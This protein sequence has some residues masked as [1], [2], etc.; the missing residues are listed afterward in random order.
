MKE[1]FYQQLGEAVRRQ[2]LPNGLEVCVVPKPE[3][4][5]KYAFFAV[6]YGGMDT[7]FSLQGR[8]MDTPAGIAHYL[9]HKMFDT[10]DGS[11]MQAL[12]Q[13]GAEPNAFTS[14]AMTAYY[15]DSTKHFE[16]NLKILLS[17]VSQPYFTKESVAKEQG[18]IRQEIRM[19]EDSPDYQIYI[20]LL[21]AM[22]GGHAAATSVV[23]S[24]ESIAQ[25][26]HQTLYDCHRAFY[27]P[28]NM[29]LTVV[30]DVDE[31]CVADLA[32]QVLPREGGPEVP[33]DYAQAPQTP[34]QR[35][36]VMEM[37]VSAPQ[38]LVGFRCPPAPEGQA[39]LQDAVLGEMALDVLMGES[40]P[41]YRRLYE[42][43]LINQSFGGTYETLPGAAYL[44]AGGDSPDAQAVIDAILEEVRRIGREG[45][46]EAYFQRLRRA[47][48]GA[49]LRGL[50]SF[51][52]IAVSLTEGYFHGYD[53]FLF[54]QVF[55]QITGADVAAFLTR[56][57]T[58]EGMALSRILPKGA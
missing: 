37:E 51:E 17:F 41:L 14:N 44:C 11:A 56:N 47:A 26:T 6:R 42:Q 48:L 32:G 23:G 58:P 22:Y 43:G 30:G 35:Q 20:R 12:S 45:V 38:F 13:N 9:E 3:Y 31:R 10:K 49:S 54:P 40:S 50:N 36:C 24:V 7:R 34:P 53:P 18:I 39:H 16:E 15:F 55:Q 33:R 8:W 19:M 5:K 57:V 1:T 2:R 28:S 25:I 29:I 52:N 4:A 46:E 21:Q 27:T